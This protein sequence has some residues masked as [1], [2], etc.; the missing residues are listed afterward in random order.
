MVAYRHLVSMCKSKKF[1][2]TLISTTTTGMF[3][4]VLFILVINYFV[5]VCINA[6]VHGLFN[7]LNNA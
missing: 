4:K 1:L 6:D 7:A 2:W 3:I 5:Y